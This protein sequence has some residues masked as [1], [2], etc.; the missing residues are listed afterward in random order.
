MK[1]YC[2]VKD[3]KISILLS[4]QRFP[5]LLFLWRHTHIAYAPFLKILSN[6]PPNILC[7]VSWAEYVIMPHCHFAQWFCGLPTQIYWR[8]DTDDMIFAS[9]LISCHTQTHRAHRDQYTDTHMWIYINTTCHVYTAATC[10][11]LCE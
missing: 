4:W 11:A 5:N 7:L 6:L 8:F 10:I 2:N 1:V 3:L 9:T